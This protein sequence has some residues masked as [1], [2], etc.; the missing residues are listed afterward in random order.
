MVLSPFK[1]N[2]HSTAINALIK[3]GKPAVSASVKLL[4]GGNTELNEY[5]QKEYLRLKEDQGTKITK[6]VEKEAAQQAS[7]QAVIVV[8]FMGTSDCV[9]PM[10]A[11]LNKGDK[12]MKAFVAG[13]L[14]KLPKSDDVTAAFKKAYT[15]TALGTKTPRGGYAKESL[16]SG[17]EAYFDLELAKWLGDGLLGKMRGEKEDVDALRQAA[18]PAH[19]VGYARDVG[20]GEKVYGMFPPVKGGNDKFF[21]KGAKDKKDEAGPVHRAADHGQDHRSR[22]QPSPTAVRRKTKRRPSTFQWH[23]TKSSWCSRTAT[24][25]R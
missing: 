5:A 18:L 11:A 24:S 3:I 22:T 10:I 7:I 13:E 14:A 15:D 25:R 21:V 1:A 4:E 19:Q 23:R 9:E 8:A 12:S 6:A 17:V 16:A 2:I 20:H